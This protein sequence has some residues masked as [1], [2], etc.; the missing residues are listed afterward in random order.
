MEKMDIEAL[1]HNEIAK[2]TIHFYLRALNKKA[3][4]MKGAANVR[5]NFLSE[6]EEALR[7]F[8]MYKKFQRSTFILQNK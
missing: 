6:R 3:H 5:M 4:N 2:Q 8:V 7:S 1:E